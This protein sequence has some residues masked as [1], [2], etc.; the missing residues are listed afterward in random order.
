MSHH[1][2]IGGTGRAGTSFLVRLLHEVG[3]ETHLSREDG[4]HDWSEEANAGLEDMLRPDG[5]DAP[6]VVKSPWLYQW[7]D[8]LLASDFV[9][10]GVILPVRDLA[11]AAASRS[12]LEYQHMHRAAPHLTDQPDTWDS[13]GSVAGG[14]V[15]STHPL[16]QTRLLAAGFF[17]VVQRLTEAAIPMYFVAFPRLALDA[18]Y[19]Y[20]QIKA[21][22]PQAISREDFV[23][24]HRRVADPA[25]IRVGSTP[26]KLRCRPKIWR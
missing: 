8:P 12:I 5:D 9:I 24:A 18:D 25:K 22:F 3:F 4:E 21:S 14:I 2:L 13:W 23:A 6:Y 11:D 20:D 15:Y 1:L 16:D 26:P 19:L 17:K 7:I 10:D